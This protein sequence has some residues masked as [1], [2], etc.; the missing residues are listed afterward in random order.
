M[1]SSEG[2]GA[3]DEGGGAEMPRE[4]LLMRQ[5]LKILRGQAAPVSRLIDHGAEA[6][7]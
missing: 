1:D 3:S 4:R 2:E 7:G 6:V 5:I